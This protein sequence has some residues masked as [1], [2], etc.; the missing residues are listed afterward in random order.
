[1]FRTLSGTV[2]FILGRCV[3]SGRCSPTRQPSLLL[4]QPRMLLPR[5]SVQ[6]WTIATA[7]CSVQLSGTSTA[8]SRRRIYGACHP[9]G[10]TVGE[11]HN[12]AAGAALASRQ[13][14]NCIQGGHAQSNE[15]GS[16]IL[17]FLADGT[18][19]SPDVGP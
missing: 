14:S 18:D 15:V 12:S 16:C 4:R 8:F 5:S 11:C 13:T 17:F 3:T 1:V 10:F 9:T 6:G 19:G 2:H 7:F